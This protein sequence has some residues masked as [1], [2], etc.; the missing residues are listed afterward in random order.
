M[1]ASETI[2][3]VLFAINS[4]IGIV[5]NALV[6]LVILRTNSLR[7]PMNYLLLNLAI[8]DIMISAFVLPRHVFFGAFNHQ[9]DSRSDFLC[10][11]ITGGVFIWIGATAEGYTLITIATER[12]LAIIHPYSFKKR[13]TTKKLRWIVPLC[14]GINTAVNTPTLVA[15]SYSKERHFCIES[16]PGWVEPRAYVGFVFIVGT[17]SVVAM[18]VLY[19]FVIYSLW[20]GQHNTIEASQNARLKMRK[21]VTQMLVIITVLHACCRLPNYTFYLLAYIAPG[22]IYGSMVYNVTVLFILFNSV[23]H[24]FLLCLHLNTFRQGIRRLLGCGNSVV[25][26]ANLMESTVQFNAGRLNYNLNPPLSTDHSSQLI[27][28]E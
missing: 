14:W 18:F 23:S 2:L 27:A 16:W 6:V 21:R 5:F 13:I 8:S 24:P 28:R 9:E 7:T 25:E 1:T 3:T 20:K 19:S 26:P 4:T 12:Y 17:S 22:A 10:K 15:L 11:F